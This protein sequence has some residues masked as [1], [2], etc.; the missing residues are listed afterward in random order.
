MVPNRKLIVMGPKK[1]VSSQQ[2]AKIDPQ[3]IED[4]EY[5]LIA[6]NL[7]QTDLEKYVPKEIQVFVESNI[8]FTIMIPNPNL[9]CGWLQSEVTRRYYEVL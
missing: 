3:Q 6:N 8:E 5:N 2:P 9:T 1:L 7:Q 4:M